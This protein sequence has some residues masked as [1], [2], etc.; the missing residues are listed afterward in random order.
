MQG[1]GEESHPL[2]Q[3]TGRELGYL[4]TG[5]LISMESVWSMRGR[6]ACFFL[7]HLRGGL[8]QTPVCKHNRIPSVTDDVFCEKPTGC[9]SSL[10]SHLLTVPSV[11]L[12]SLSL[13]VL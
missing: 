10:P 3:E 1:T 4:L 2:E 12:P 6:S 13:N 11:S 7:E 9:V 5:V 8:C